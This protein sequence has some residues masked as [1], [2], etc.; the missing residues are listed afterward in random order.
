MKLL[1]L[2]L[3]ALFMT[4]LSACKEDKNK[5]NNIINNPAQKSID[6]YEENI[7]SVKNIDDFLNLENK[8]NSLKIN[9]NL[10]SDFFLEELSNYKAEKEN[11]QHYI[12]K[13]GYQEGVNLLDYRVIMRMFT[14]EKDLDKLSNDSKSRNIN[15]DIWS[16]D[17]EVKNNELGTFFDMKI[18]TEIENYRRIEVLLYSKSSKS[19][20]GD[21]VLIEKELMDY[22]QKEDS[23]S[24]TAIQSDLGGVI[25]AENIFAFQDS[26]EEGAY[27][28]FKLK[29]D[30][31]E[32]KLENYRIVI[33]TYP[34][35]EELNLLREDS[36]EKE[37]DFDAWYM[38]PSIISDGN[39]M[40]FFAYLKTQVLDFKKVDI[41]VYDKNQK[42]YIGLPI[43]L[44][45]FSLNKT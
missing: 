39:E 19:Y 5:E 24:N 16:S 10:G 27:F 42:R 29:E 13:I 31:S 2:I 38:D 32:S 34:L 14:F 40:F 33:M 4:N 1:K 7:V 22:L 25:P 17:L 3:L 44:E 23:Y 21:R 43:S 20:I 8:P 41:R 36:L 37:S 26:N 30:I 12:L 11:E 35:E 15:M 45:Y 18:E 6:L 9:K 28:V